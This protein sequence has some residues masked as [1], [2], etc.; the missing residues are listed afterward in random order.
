V[1]AG[2]VN[3]GVSELKQ[4]K[5]VTFTVADGLASNRVSAIENGD[6]GTMWFGTAAGLSQVTGG[7]W[8]TYK[9]R[10]GLPADEV[11]CLTRDQSGVLWVGTSAGLASLSGGTLHRLSNGPEAL[12][13]PILGLMDD[14]LGY[15]WIA[16]ADRVL[17]VK[18]EALLQGKVTAADMREFGFADGL[19]GTVGVKRSQLVVRD[20]EGQIWFS[21]NGGLSQVH[22]ARAMHD[23]TPPVVR[24]EAILVDGTPA[25]LQGTVQIP[26]GQRRMVI[27]FSALSLAGVKPL[28]F[29]YRLDGF[30][31][32]WSEPV[33]RQAVY[34][35]LNPGAYTFRLGAT[36][37]YGGW[38]SVE[39]AISLEI[40]P[41][42]WQTWWFRLSALL[43]LALLTWLIYRFRLLQISRQV[44]LRVEERANERARIGR[45]LHDSLLQGFQGL[46]LHL[47]VAKQM[48]PDR[49]DETK[50]AL[51]RVLDQGDQ[52]LAEA[53][54]AV[55]NLRGGA[56]ATNDLAQALAAVGKELLE[57]DQGVNFRVLVEGK[58]QP[59][60]PILRDEVYRFAREGLR[61]AFSHARA[62]NIEAELTFAAD[63][64]LLRVRD[65]GIGIDPA[66]LSLGRRP[67]HWGLPGMRERAESVGAVM[68]LWSESGAGTEVQ[69]DVPGDIAYEASATFER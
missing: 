7:T 34:T 28:R 35:N 15:L 18:R 13:E 50:E 8:R 64:L 19:H 20:P 42:F 21:L 33:A 38:N 1:W 10:E 23:P 6:E 36:N 52:A 39:Q 62:Q 22:P 44:E 54:S 41:V 57:N 24:V 45:E 27:D 60:N 9:V 40:A 31:H 67:G 46:L 17:R 2:T 49:P 5:F 25:N 29:R 30:D 61:N 53:R 43:F 26:A 3:G 16:T 4:E 63:R 56:S 59:L 51:E 32:G 48:L 65:D 69:L 68:E 11:M 12:R 47:E 37:I 66:V 14:D 55:Q 58:P